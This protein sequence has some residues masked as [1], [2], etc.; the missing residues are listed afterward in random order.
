M[1]VAFHF[2]VEMPLTQNSNVKKVNVVGRGIS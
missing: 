2:S 1:F